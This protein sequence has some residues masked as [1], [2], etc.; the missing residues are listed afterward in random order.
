MLRWLAKHCDT[1]RLTLVEKFPDT[2]S[3]VIAKTIAITITCVKAEA[4][5]KTDGDIDAG[6]QAYTDVDTIN[7]FQAFALVHRKAYTFS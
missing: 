5:V 3:E 2:L 1:C 4:Q 7:E 6:L